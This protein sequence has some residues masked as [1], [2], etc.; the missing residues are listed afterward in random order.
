MSDALPP[1]AAAHP[2]RVTT[3]PATRV[4]RALGWVAGAVSGVMVLI[5]IFSWAASGFA[6]LPGV[7]AL[8]PALVA[9][10]TLQA[11][12]FVVFGLILTHRLPRHPVSW[13]FA[14]AGFLSAARTFGW[15]VA[16]N[17]ATGDASQLRLDPDTVVW[18]TTGTTIAGTQLAITM[19]VLLFPDGRFPSMRARQLT[20]VAIASALAL[21][22]ALSLRPGP[23][24]LLERFESPISVGPGIADVL[25]LLEALGGVGAVIALVGAAWTMRVRYERGD[26]LLRRQL[27]WFAWAVAIVAVPFVAFVLLRGL[28]PTGSPAAELVGV[29]L[30]L[31][32]TLLPLAVT[33][34]ILR[35]G[36]WAIDRLISL[37]FVYASLLA[38]LA[39]I[40]AATLSVLD[41]IFV[42]AAGDTSATA[43]AITTLLL[44]TLAT[45][46]QRRLDAYA[47]RRLAQ[48]QERDR[49]ASDASADAAE[50][51]FATRLDQLDARVARLEVSGGGSS[52]PRGAR[53]GHTA[54]RRR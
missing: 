30:F 47:E 38:I 51:P 54:H 50:V 29:G 39:G 21:G 20:W 17:A 40:Y 8:S 16:T 15:G 22:L 52:P 32:L 43:H 34:A 41:G 33:L 46:I 31:A 4:L 3:P 25:P 26:R 35:H 10:A 18:A 14:A 1:A 6:P 37:T 48:A 53:R 27:R 44:V 45:P 24:V 11:T 13:A 23:V 36:L 19:L 42:S 5:G 9:S 7:F 12:S 28:L 49:D 2:V